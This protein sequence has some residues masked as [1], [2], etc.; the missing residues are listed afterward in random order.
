MPDREE[1]HRHHVTRVLRTLGFAG[2]A[3]N[4]PVDNG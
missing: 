3:G 1:T 2:N 4:K